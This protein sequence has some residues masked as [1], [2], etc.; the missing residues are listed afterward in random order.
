MMLNLCVKLGSLTSGIVCNGNNMNAVRS[1]TPSF[2]AA[3]S[4][5]DNCFTHNCYNAS[6]TL[7]L[8]S[9]PFAV[10]LSGFGKALTIAEMQ[11][12]SQILNEFKVVY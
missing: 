7:G 4:C 12:Y 10:R 8:A 3:T 2:D 1:G 11:K 6:T 9:D 5:S